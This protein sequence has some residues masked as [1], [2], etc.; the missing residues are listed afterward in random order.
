MVYYWQEEKN[1]KWEAEMEIFRNYELMRESEEIVQRNNIYYPRLKE[2]KKRGR[3]AF[4]ELYKKLCISA[5]DKTRYMDMDKF[6]LI[7]CKH[8]KYKVHIQPTK[9]YG[10]EIE[11]MWILETDISDN[12]AK[13]LKDYEYIQT[14]EM[15]YEENEQDKVYAITSLVD[16]LKPS[17]KELIRLI[18]VLVEELEHSS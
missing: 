2:T 6:E 10:D 8:K 18:K 4:I 1:E 16:N 14:P 12:I 5:T 17:N 15:P 9:R 11:S 7:V 3:H 13:Y